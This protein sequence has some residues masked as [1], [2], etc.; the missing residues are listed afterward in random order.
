MVEN[1]PNA[2]DFIV[3]QPVLDQMDWLIT[4]VVS[5]RPKQIRNE[6]LTKN[7]NPGFITR[8]QQ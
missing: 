4:F 2:K 5:V 1:Y 6:Y 7:K 3:N 8:C